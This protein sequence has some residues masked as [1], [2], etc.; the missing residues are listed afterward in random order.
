MNLNWETILYP[1]MIIVALTG[2][3]LTILLVIRM[4][5]EDKEYEKRRLQKERDRYFRS[6]W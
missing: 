2:L 6:G 3:A 4:K 1:I 5:R